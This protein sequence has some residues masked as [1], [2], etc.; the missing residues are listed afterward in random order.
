MDVHDVHKGVRGRHEWA[1]FARAADG[2]PLVVERVRV[3]KLCDVLGRKKDPP[4]EWEIV[5]R[6]LSPMDA[7]DREL[8]VTWPTGRI[9]FYLRPHTEGTM[10]WAV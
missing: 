5:N 1:A 4:S 10:K 8:V 3:K 6:E 9:A 2:T 7:G